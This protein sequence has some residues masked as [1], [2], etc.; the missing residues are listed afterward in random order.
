MTG[1]T[2]QFRVP[3]GVAP[4]APIAS[5]QQ[6]L[7]H[8]A[9]GEKPN[10]PFRVGVELE[11]LPIV[12]DGHAAPYEADGPS[13]TA[14][15]RALASAH[16][17][18]EVVVNDHLVGLAGPDGP[19][20][21]EPGGQVEL[22]LP[23][24]VT[25]REV[26]ADLER[27][28]ERLRDAGRACGVTLVTMGLQP[29]TPVRDIAWNPR[30]RYRIMREHLGRRGRLAHHMMKATAG[31]QFNVDHA[32][33]QDA[34]ALMRAALGASPVMNA[35]AANSPLEEGRENGWLT[36]RPHVW[37][38]T[39][40]ERT[41]LLTWLHDEGF[42]YERWLRWTLSAPVMFVVRDDEWVT[43]GDRTFA[44]LIERGH[45]QAGAAQH[46]DFALHLTTLFPEVRLKQHVEI[47]G[48]D[49]GEPDIV[50]AGAA[51]WRGAL[52]DREA[53]G[54]I[55][56]MTDPWSAAEREALHEA[57][58]REGLRA[59][60]RGRTLQALSLDMLDVAEDG[61][62]RLEGGADD[63]ALLHPLRAIARSGRTRAE[64]FL[65]DW[66]A[67]GVAAVL[68]RG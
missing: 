63:V 60:I 41:G 54:A 20:H 29:V 40:A 35:L 44:E 5:R 15:L 64:T 26:L 17:L 55:V 2:P 52:Y 18:A 36:I 27:W 22:A 12:G 58:A 42:S 53:R 34:A 39:D 9:A 19:I 1:R 8:F 31:T 32:S 48:A 45:P 21:L 13:V 66:R 62:R 49:S 16:G 68:A 57:A 23:P 10:G 43:I 6:L 37:R 51:F 56:A 47:R 59:S 67:R 33:E 30:N 46:Q 25:A 3:E 65:D 11:M 50:A 4:H 61:L 14:L 28:R 38:N 7:A 24:R